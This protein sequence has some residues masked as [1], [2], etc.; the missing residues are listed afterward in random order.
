MRVGGGK[1]GREREERGVSAE[2]VVEMDKR[3]GETGEY[4]KDSAG[5]EQRESVLEGR[6]KTRERRILGVGDTE[7][8][9]ED[10]WGNSA[11][12]L[13]HTP[14]QARSCRWRGRRTAG[15]TLVGRRSRCSAQQHTHK[16]GSRAR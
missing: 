7:G 16:R 13:A 11:R 4:G 2:K 8:R 12:A 5:V 14:A 3:E 9:F 10:F 1:G 15:G 6:V